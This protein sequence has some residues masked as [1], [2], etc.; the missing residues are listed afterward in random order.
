MQNDLLSIQQLANLLR[1]S[2]KTLRRYDKAGILVP[3]RTAGNHRRY[4]KDQVDNFLG[5]KDLRPII[6]ESPTPTT[7]TETPT[8]EPSLLTPRRDMPQQQ[9]SPIQNIYSYTNTNGKSASSNFLPRM[10]M[11]LALTLVLTAGMFGVWGASS[12]QEFVAQK[13]T[14]QNI[15]NYQKEDTLVLGEITSKASPFNFE[16]IAKSIS[17]T[18]EAVGSSILSFFN[19]T[20]PENILTTKL[21]TTGDTILGDSSTDKLTINSKVMTFAG[22]DKTI[23]L[24]GKGTKT[25]T[26]LNSTSSGIA[27]LDLADGDLLTN[28]ITRITNN[29]DAS[30]VTLRANFFSTGSIYATNTLT[31]SGDFTFESLSPQILIADTG[32]LSITDG[33]NTLLK[34]TDNG[35]TGSLE[36]TGDLKVSGNMT[37]SGK[38]NDNTFTSTT[39]LFAGNSPSITTGTQD[40]AISLD[41]GTTGAVNIAGAS[42]GDVNIAG[43]ASSTGCTITNSNGNLNCAG[44]ITATSNLIVN[45]GS[46]TTS[47]T[48]FNLLNTTPTT[49]NIGG[50]ATTISIGATTG[51]TTINNA[52]ALTGDLAVN[53]GNITTNSTTASIFNTTP[54]TLSIGGAATTIN[55]GSSLGTT[56]IAN[57]LT[58]SGRPTFTIAPTLPHTGTWAIGSS[59]WNANDA[60][61]YINPTSATGDSNLLSLA[62]GGSV[63]FSVDAEGDTYLNNLILAGN[64][65]SATT[66]IAG[67]LAVEGNTT[68]GDTTT[69]TLTIN[70]ATAT[71]AGGNK[72]FDITGAATRTLTLLN[73]TT[74]QVA[75]L[76]LSD[77]SLFTGG[78]A[79]IDNSGNLTNIGTVTSGLINSQTISSSASFTGTV[80]VATSLNS[81]I[82]YGG[83]G[84]TSTLT[85]RSTSG[86]GATGAD[87]IFGVGNNG[88]TEAMRILNNGNVGIGDVNPT[89]QLVARSSA[90]SNTGI[91]VANTNTSGTMNLFFNYDSTDN[92]GTGNI[93][94]IWA[95]AA[96]NDLSIGL[97]QM[98]GSAAD[99]IF[100]ASVGSNGSYDTEIGRLRRSG[101]FQLPTIGSSAGIL[102]GGDTNL[103]RGAGNVLT[104]DDSFFI[105]DSANSLMTLGLTINQ[106]AADDEILALKSS[107]VAHGITAITE[108]DTF[109]LFTKRD[110]TGGG[111][112]IRGLDGTNATGFSVFGIGGADNTT[113]SNTARGFIDLDTGK[114]TGVGLTSPGANANL[115]T[116]RDGVSGVTRF[117]FDAEGDSWQTGQIQLDPSDGG[118]SATGIV[119]GSAADVNLYRSAT[120]TLKTDDNF[121][122]GGSSLTVSDGSTVFT[123]S[124]TIADN[125]TIS[126]SQTGATVGTDYAGYFT[127]TG[128]ATTNVGLYATATGATNNYAAIFENGNVGIGTTTP[129]SKLEVN[130]YANTSYTELVAFSGAKGA[131]V[132]IPTNQLAVVDTTSM[133]AGVGG[134]ISFEGSYT[135]TSPT[136]F[137]AI[138]GVKSNGTNGNHDGDFTI[139]TRVN[140]GN[141]TEKLRITAAGQI[142]A[143]ITGV[144]GG[145]MI[146][147]DFQIYRL[148]ANFGYTPNTFQ[149]GGAFQADTTAY[150]PATSGAGSGL[151]IGGDTNLYRGAANRLDL[152]SGD[153]FSV[154]SGG[155][156]IGAANT[157]ANTFYL[158]GASSPGGTGSVFDVNPTMSG[159]LNLFNFV[160]RVRGSFTTST[161]MLGTGNGGF[162]M[163]GIDTEALNSSA[164]A[165]T[166][167]QAS[168]IYLEG[169]PSAGTDITITNAY[170]LFVDSGLTR[171]DGGIEVGSLS[172]ANTT[173][174]CWDN[175]GN[176]LIY[177]CNGSATD[178]AELY[179]TTDASI[180]AADVVISAGE[181]Q[182]IADPNE[183]EHTSRAYI[184]KATEPYQSDLI[185][186]ISTNPNQVYGEDGVFAD[187]D[188]PRPV[189]L[190]GRVPVKVT[191]QNGSIKTGDAI[192]SSTLAGVGM[193]A[194]QAG[195]IVGI[196]LS[197]YE[198]TDTAAVGTVIV[199]VNPSWYDPDVYLTSTG[200]LSIT[201]I[202]DGGLNVENGYLTLEDGSSNLIS[203]IQ[204]QNTN[205]YALSSTVNGAVIR[206]GAF[207][208]AAI[209]NLRA[210]SIDVQSLTLAGTNLVDLLGIRGL[211]PKEATASDSAV[212]N[213]QQTA[214]QSSM[215]SRIEKL[216]QASDSFLLQLNESA[217]K[218][219]FLASM[220]GGE[221]LGASTSSQ[222]LLPQNLEIKQATVS[223]DLMV[224]G[225]STFSDVGITGIVN[226]G[227]LSING[228]DES[229]GNSFASINSIKDLYLQSNGAGGINILN[230]KVVI[231]QDG[232]LVSSGEITAEKYNVDISDNAS[233]T[234]GQGKISKDTTSTT[235]S[236]TSIGI[237]SKIFVTARSDTDKPLIVKNVVAGKSFDVT[238]LSSYVSDI[239]FDWWII[240]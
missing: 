224:L 87:I 28:G 79:R 95:S 41:A 2:T 183:G 89:N 68:F 147:G 190:A 136:S 127:N 125:K 122:F 197:G 113:K 50:A 48:T 237:D 156:G 225:R 221:V 157:N 140:G 208:D 199:F 63:K 32:V 40:T 18:I 43:G 168:G 120:N 66:T 182:A 217:S 126:V 151:V 15:S 172:T 204:P 107:D 209:G 46:F 215:L 4:T 36:T 219:A 238:I 102:I 134:A 222:I 27:N 166:I 131:F 185:G 233:T 10:K 132:G 33:T 158:T 194:T 25:L 57:N 162:H 184:A 77:G 62:V 153:S 145:I 17:N 47:Q 75:N 176:S 30:F 1:V 207:Q 198:N 195:R 85:L 78:T 167:A 214:T 119:F 73:S 234:L 94:R 135:G 114:K 70:P 22:G 67:D 205:L 71:F 181:A 83:T 91:T 180:E 23:D 9:Q 178:L 3:I 213:A 108:T 49:L 111:L 13:Q 56:T 112:R 150:F 159:N 26:L 212:L 29:G 34:L 58:F 116:I 146:G 220:L 51:T 100:F 141:I 173:A 148:D 171:L 230:G 82:V 31:T 69:D 21:T 170:A 44:N 139:G 216:E 96:S 84:T 42:T 118:T 8:I 163:L 154:V 211:T 236:T 228:L 35:T 55:F 61:V 169:A 109:G 93:G 177:D 144:S 81:P 90:A 227:L 72:T 52:L 37:L 164:G 5:L 39:L 54:T 124:S 117:I 175:S 223:G 11:F 104:T 155:V 99:L 179:G 115:V 106:G 203:S 239:K 101:Q 142:Q 105:N 143:P 103:Y 59:N 129:L 19:P 38:I 218:S 231:G 232:N 152:A 123:S 174:L 92:L 80:A 161:A 128:A 65:S 160:A 187:S 240:N 165:L 226:I 14:A 186:V 12:F 60:S 53:G 97:G 88:A 45:G 229:L 196:A 74:S 189:S 201:R 133:A 193:R 137:A 24:T 121:I 149:V 7:H 20:P 206:V 210:G 110:A 192:T 191:T 98:G 76:D 138:A 202:D 188:N 235:I 16:A 200:D 86:V 6:H 64:I 130:D